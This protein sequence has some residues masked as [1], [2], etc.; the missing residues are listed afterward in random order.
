MPRVI[1]SAV[2]TP[3]AGV[4]TSYTVDSITLEKHSGRQIDIN[5]LVTDFAV[6][7]SI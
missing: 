7:E 5:A 4:P 6:S 2:S 1:N 3:E